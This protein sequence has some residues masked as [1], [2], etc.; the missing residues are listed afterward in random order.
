[1]KISVDIMSK[2]TAKTVG[3]FD[4][5][6]VCAKKLQQFIHMLL[7]WRNF[8]SGLMKFNRNVEENNARG[9][10]RL[11]TIQ[12]ISCYNNSNNDINDIN[13]KEINQPVAPGGPRKPGGPGGP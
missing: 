10:I 12:S 13:V 11:I 4:I 5:Q 8:I 9:V 6:S 3:H 7:E 1:M 2:L